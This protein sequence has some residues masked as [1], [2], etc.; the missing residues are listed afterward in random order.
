MAAD[1]ERIE[2]HTASGRELP[3]GLWGMA[4]V[5][6]LE[7]VALALLSLQEPIP[8]YRWIAWLYLAMAL[9]FLPL[10]WGRHVSWIE[11]GPE[12]LVVRGPV[13]SRRIPMQDVVGIEAHRHWHNPL[14]T[15]RPPW[16]WLLI[17]RTRGRGW[18]VEYIA[19]EAGDRLLDALH[20]LRKPILVYNWQ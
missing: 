6:T 15:G 2:N 3:V 20:R 14:A 4:G 7:F 18:R 10:A 13:R 17:R 8:D 5:L 16:Y 11:V 19:P 9:L 1:T 12:T